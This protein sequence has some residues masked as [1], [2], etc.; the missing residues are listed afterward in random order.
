MIQSHVKLVKNV[1]GDAEW[2]GRVCV[3]ALYYIMVIG[4]DSRDPSILL[5][6]K[7]RRRINYHINTLLQ[8]GAFLNFYKKR[9]NQLVTI[10]K[11]L[12]I[13]VSNLFSIHE[14]LL[15]FIRFVWLAILPRQI[16]TYLS[17]RKFC[18]A[19]ITKVPS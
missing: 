19:H 10:L 3:A 16:F 17:R 2:K 13:S 1:L 8:D 5:L 12:R 15:S 11:F 14:Q 9:H 4:P 7:K 18:F 6:S